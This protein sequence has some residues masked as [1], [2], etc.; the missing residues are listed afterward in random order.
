MSVLIFKENDH[1]NFL[2]NKLEKFVGAPHFCK[3]YLVHTK[4][5]H[6]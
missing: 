6:L 3:S 2:I 4:I 1:L 5:L